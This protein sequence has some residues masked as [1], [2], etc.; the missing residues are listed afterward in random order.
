MQ[1]R[2]ELSIQLVESLDQLGAESV[3][4]L[5][6]NLRQISLGTIPALLNGDTRVLRQVTH[7]SSSNYGRM[8]HVSFILARHILL[9]L[10]EVHSLATLGLVTD[11]SF[12]IALQSTGV[13][14]CPRLVSS[15]F[16]IW[17]QGVVMFTA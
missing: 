1:Y 8:P 9:G 7:M 4:F 17:K 14:S 13:G 11:S 3:A 5:T 12:F 15:L 16:S 6:K 2:D 10:H